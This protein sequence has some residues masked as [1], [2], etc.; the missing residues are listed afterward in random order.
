MRSTNP[1]A[2]SLVDDGSTRPLMI[3]PCCSRCCIAV[4]LAEHDGAQFGAQFGAD[5]RR[6]LGHAIRR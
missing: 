3:W 4:E 2:R 1:E 6:R 5:L